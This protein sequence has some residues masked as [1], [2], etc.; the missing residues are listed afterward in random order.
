MPVLKCRLHS[1]LKKY[2]YEAEQE[3]NYVVSY[4]E[5]YGDNSRSQVHSSS[6]YDYEVKYKNYKKTRQ[7]K[8][9]QDLGETKSQSKYISKV[10]QKYVRF[11]SINLRNHRMSPSSSQLNLAPNGNMY[12]AFYPN[13]EELIDIVPE[14]LI[15]T[16]LDYDR[17]RFLKN[18][19]GHIFVKYKGYMSP[20]QHFLQ[21][22]G[23]KLNKKIQKRNKRKPYRPDNYFD[24]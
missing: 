9:V 24:E 18:I 16:M 14:H 15:E 2:E 21:T 3:P 19:Q 12:F 4:H 17:F 11:R 22:Y 6:Q 1:E 10:G 5:K 13:Y 8:S 23:N 7:F 20:V